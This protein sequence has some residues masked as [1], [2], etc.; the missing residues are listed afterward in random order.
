MAVSIAEL[1]HCEQ[2]RC[3]RA[4]MSPS[5]SQEASGDTR[6][7][8]CRAGFISTRPP[9]ENVAS[10]KAEAVS[11]KKLTGRHLKGGL[12]NSQLCSVGRGS[13]LREL[14]TIPHTP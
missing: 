9:S 13:G 5:R 7:K 11:S 14:S 4:V 10:G 1:T 3:L 12:W 8:Y 6:N 2:T